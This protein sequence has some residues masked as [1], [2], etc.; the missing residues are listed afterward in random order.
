MKDID[1]PTWARACLHASL[2]GSANANEPRLT[3]VDTAQVR[4]RALAF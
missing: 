4:K 2:S 1:L 3:P